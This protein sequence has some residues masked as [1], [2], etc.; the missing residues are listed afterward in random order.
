MLPRVRVKVERRRICHIA[1][2]V[3][4]NN[5]EV[6]ADLLMP[7][8]ACVRIKRIADRILGAHVTPPSVLYE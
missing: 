4:G 7:R 1:S 5:R 6:I 3:V 2:G 8:K